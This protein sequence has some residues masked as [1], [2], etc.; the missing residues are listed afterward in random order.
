MSYISVPTKTSTAQYDFNFASWD[1]EFNNI[2]APLDVYPIFDNRL[3]QYPV[4]FYN[5]EVLLQ[6]SLE[7]YGTYAEYRGDTSEIKRMLGG[8]P[9]NYFEFA[10]WT[11]NFD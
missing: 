6:E 7:Y 11:P 1:K 10:Y 2:I 9:S 3:R 4:Y 8:Q 5:G